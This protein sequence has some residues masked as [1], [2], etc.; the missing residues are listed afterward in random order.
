[1][2]AKDAPR[3]QTLRSL[4]TAMTNEVVAKK[5]KPDELLTDDEAI[6]VLKKAKASLAPGGS[7]F[8]KDNVPRRM[9]YFSDDPALALH[10]TTRHLQYLFEL[11]GLVEKRESELQSGWP[12]ALLKL[13]MFLLQPSP[14]EG[15]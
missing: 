13:R 3:L 8:V 11:A 1:M 2:R 15:L 7:I 10:R 6:D 12:D 14:T 4:I 5:R 9:W